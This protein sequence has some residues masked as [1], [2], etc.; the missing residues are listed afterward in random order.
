M[1]YWNALFIVFFIM[2]AA[3]CIQIWLSR[4]VTVL[5]GIKTELKIT[6]AKLT[7]IQADINTI[8]NR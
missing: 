6:N 3:I 4:I 5:E 8:K 7:Y 2:A 1:S